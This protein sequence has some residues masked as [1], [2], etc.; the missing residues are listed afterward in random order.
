MALDE[1]KVLKEITELRTAL[2]KASAKLTE[3]DTLLKDLTAPPFVCGVVVT[4]SDKL[5]TVELKKLLLKKGIKAHILKGEHEGETGIFKDTMNSKAIRVEYEGDGDGDYDLYD[6]TKYGSTFTS[7]AYLNINDAMVVVSVENSFY[8]IK[9]PEGV[10]VEPGQTVRLH[11]DTKAFISIAP[12][13]FGGDLCYVRQV[14]QNGKCEIEHEGTTRMVFTGRTSPEKGDRVIIDASASVVLKNM[15]KEDERF[16]FITDTNIEWTDIGGLENA[17]RTLREIIELPHTHKQLFQKFKKRP[18]KGVLL[19]GPPGCGKT[20]L[21]KAAATAIQKFCEKKAKSGFM[22]V[23]GPEILDK[24]VGVAEATIRSIFDRA[25]LHK[26]ETGFPAVVFLDEADAV[27]GRRGSGI[28]SDIERTIVPMFLAEMD[29]LEESGALLILAT[30][31]P[32]ILDPAVTREGRMDRKIKVPRPE[33]HSALTIL[34]LGF[35]DMPFTAPFSEQEA[36][37]LACKEFFDQ[38]RVLYKI[39]TKN[40]EQLHFRLA[41]LVSGGMLVN[42]AEQASSIAF[43]RHLETAKTA[44]TGG[45]T[46]SDIIEAVNTLETQVRDVSHTD[47]LEEFIYD[48]KDSVVDIKKV[49]PNTKTK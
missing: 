32:D 19:Y 9:I 42:I 16:T 46:A 37:T 38:K 44:V 14:S 39:H 36:A 10:S 24:Y 3:Q 15:G 48:F 34:G 45:I 6:L 18:A 21:G 22:Y 8:E 43:H 47:E 29:G 12:T 31:R 4:N 27:L 2:Q 49:A 25:R 30:N 41:N 17:K 26:L 33:Q 11:Q 13:E 20:M 5:T 1:G 28:S 40:N 35:K 7:P 23:K